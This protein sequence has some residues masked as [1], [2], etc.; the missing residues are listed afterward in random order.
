[1]ADTYEINGKFV[2][3]EEYNAFIAKNPTCGF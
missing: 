2:S 1:M 3:E